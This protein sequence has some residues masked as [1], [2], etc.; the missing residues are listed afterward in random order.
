MGKKIGGI[1]AI[2]GTVDFTLLDDPTQTTSALVKAAQEVCSTIYSIEFGDRS[3]CY[4]EELPKL[5]SHLR[6]LFVSVEFV[7]SPSSKGKLPSGSD[8]FQVEVSSAYRTIAAFLTYDAEHLRVSDWAVLARTLAN[9][10]VQLTLFVEQYGE[11]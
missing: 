7:R 9:L 3:S 1:V 11:S 6:D 8:I 2:G 4:A 10:E 5:A